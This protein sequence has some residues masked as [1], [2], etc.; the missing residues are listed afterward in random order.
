LDIY[1]ALKREK[2]YLKRFYIM[3]IILEI[4]MPLAV[5]LTGLSTFFYISYLLFMELLIAVAI[6][7]KV[8]YTRL[9]FFCSNNRLKFKSVVF[10]KENLILCDKVVL[11]HTERMEENM[12]IILIT[13][14]NFKNKGLKLI[15]EGFL[16]K[17]SSISHEY[18]KIKE[19]NPK[20]LYYCQIIKRGGLKKYMLLD[21]IYRNCVK[22]EY[23]EEGIQNIKI[24][25]GQTLV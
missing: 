10:S 15:G 6:M 4:I 19:A 17:Y 1:K 18:L 25:R 24:A 9:K 16:K 2:K 13:S 3:M 22:A 11:V 12:E 7:N 5:Y 21:I 23:T 14:V 20:T 8:N